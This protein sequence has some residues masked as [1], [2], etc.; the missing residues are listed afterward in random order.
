MDAVTCISGDFWVLAPSLL[1]SPVSLLG[2]T[3]T[4]TGL[5]GAAV[6]SNLKNQ[7]NGE[8]V[9]CEVMQRWVIYVRRPPPRPPPWVDGWDGTKVTACPCEGDQLG[10]RTS[11]AAQREQEGSG[12]GEGRSEPW[13]G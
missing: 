2:F 4:Q 8:A 9:G 10:T 6:E 1:I 13:K 3:L 7:N 12:L 5:R 11:A